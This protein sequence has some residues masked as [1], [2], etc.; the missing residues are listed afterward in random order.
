MQLE[1]ASADSTALEGESQPV[2]LSAADGHPL[3]A[4]LY[5]HAV[6]GPRAVVIVNCAMA[7]PQ[8]FYEAFARHLAGRGL[9]VL[10]YDYR[11]IGGSRRAREIGGSLRGF[12][13]HAREWARLDFSA[14]MKWTEERFPQL[15]RFAVGHSFGG[16]A[17][18]FTPGAENLAGAV[19]VASQS[20]YWGHWPPSVRWRMAFYWYALFPAICAL[21]GYMPGRLGLGEDVPKGVILEWARWC[22]HPEYAFGYL[23]DAKAQAASFRAPVLALSFSDDPY[24]PGPS[25]DALLG[26]FRGTRPVHRPLAPAEVGLDRI[27]HF[28]FFRKGQSKLWSIVELWLEARLR[29]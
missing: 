15:P 23:D 7:V 14:V 26:Y 17:I 8:R 13:A 16:Q 9:A 21:W 18:S 4:A 1:A 12:R 10:T 22:R 5:Q 25:V 29:E 28:G 3:A 27:G 6:G 2:V 11:G 24:A 20:G 19:L